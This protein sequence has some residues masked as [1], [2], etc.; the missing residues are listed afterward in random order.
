MLG[1]FL[2]NGLAVGLVAASALAI[3]ASVIYLA[4]RRDPADVLPAALILVMVAPAACVNVFGALFLE[5]AHMI[6]AL[7]ATLIAVLLATLGSARWSARAT[8][9]ALPRTE[10]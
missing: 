4:R 3:A 6:L 7:G 8:L 5:E 2:V 9:S 10:P 1:G